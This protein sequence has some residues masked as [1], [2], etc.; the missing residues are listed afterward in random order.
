MNGK[1]EY[2]SQF[3]DIEIISYIS[4]A[5]R[6]LSIPDLEFKRIYGREYPDNLFAKEGEFNLETTIGEVKYTKYG[7]WLYR[8]ILRQQMK[9]TGSKKAKQIDET[10]CADAVQ[11]ARIARIESMP[12]RSLV[13]FSEGKF[14]YSAAN[15]LLMILNG[16]KGGLKKLR[17][18]YLTRKKINKKNNKQI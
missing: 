10:K 1:K 4:L 8:F 18:A 12:I 2:R 3:Q 6:T 16:K 17:D 11:T 14:D 15:A 13:L 7:K 5:N 9:S